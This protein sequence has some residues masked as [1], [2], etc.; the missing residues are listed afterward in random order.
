MR[1]GIFDRGDPL[2]TAWI[3]AW[4]PRQL[5]HDPIHLFDA[6]IFHPFRDTFAYTENILGPALLAA[7]ARLFTSNPIAVQNFSILTAFAA[8]G[9]AAYLYFRWISTSAVAAACGAVLVALSPVRFGQLGHIQLLHT[10]GLP[11]LLFSLQAHFE[12]PRVSSALLVA[13]AMLFEFLSSFYLAT[14]AGLTL[15][16][17]LL[18]ALP[19]FGRGRWTAACWRLI[20]WLGLSLLIVIPVM[21]PYW[22]LARDFGFVRSIE[23]MWGNWASHKDYVRPLFGS[24]A[25]RIA[26]RYGAPAG[27]SLYLGCLAIL[28]ALVGLWSVRA[29]VRGKPNRERFAAGLFVAL[30]IAFFVLSLGGWRT[31]GSHR[32]LLP[33]YWLHALPGFEG[34]RVPWRFGV[35]VDLAVAGLAVLGLARIHR[36]L[37]ARVPYAAAPIPVLLIGVASVVERVPPLPLVPVER[38]EVGQEVPE[39]YRWLASDSTAAGVLEL[40]MATEKRERES[41][42]VVQYRQVYYTTYHWQRTL[43]GL[44]GYTPPAYLELQDRMGRF[45]A[46][47]CFRLL[48]LLPINRVVIHRTLYSSPIPGSL[49]EEQGFPVLYDTKE[50]LV[51]EVHQAPV[52]RQLDPRLEV[53][54]EPSPGQPLALRVRWNPGLPEFVY[55]PVRIQFRVRSTDASGR[56]RMTEER[57]WLAVPVPKDYQASVEPGTRTLAFTLTTDQGQKLERAWTFAGPRNP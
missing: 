47:E 4:G 49:L 33:F 20:P 32:I 52:E 28:L 23:G 12:R 40:P 26:G 10:A 6:N 48:K 39:V 44:S 38:V 54:S 19:A 29:A 8:L 14:V 30:G 37:R 22:R 11:L 3:L 9:L 50:A 53:L 17:F 43:N 46:P 24:F 2:L 15:L 5:L 1:D 31:I 16:V 45:P 36:W 34:I 13:A 18:L 56:K 21:I 42:D 51:A 35:V 57:A 25:G 41:W 7:P 27:K 55:P